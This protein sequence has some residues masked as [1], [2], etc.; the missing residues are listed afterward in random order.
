MRT[1]QSGMTDS[2]SDRNIDTGPTRFEQPLAG[3]REN[4]I[5]H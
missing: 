1:A 5:P 3:K 4:L 2:E